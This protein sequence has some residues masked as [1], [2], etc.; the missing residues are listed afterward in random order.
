MIEHPPNDSK[1]QKV[2]KYCQKNVQ[3]FLQTRFCFDHIPTTAIFHIFTTTVIKQ[4]PPITKCH[5]IIPRSDCGGVQVLTCKNFHILCTLQQ[6]YKLFNS[7]FHWI[8]PIFVI[9]T[10]GWH[11]IL[12]LCC[13]H[14]KRRCCIF[15]LPAK[16]V[17][18]FFN[19]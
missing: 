2:R 8:V 17:E 6:F 13:I 5:Y 19:I 15:A 3:N 16:R 9:I 18:M 1:I 10:E 7:L 11:A 4:R 14:T 12:L